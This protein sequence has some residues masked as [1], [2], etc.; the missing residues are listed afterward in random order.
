MCLICVEYVER[1]SKESLLN[2]MPLW[3]AK[4][5][6]YFGSLS[7]LTEAAVLAGLVV[8]CWMRGHLLS[9]GSQTQHATEELGHLHPERKPLRAETLSNKEC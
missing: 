6:R 4:R 9:D 3:E 5:F 8:R 7:Q 1:L 2:L